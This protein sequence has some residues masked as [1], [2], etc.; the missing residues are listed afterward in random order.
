MYFIILQNCL[1]W[2]DT[3]LLG[4]KAVKEDWVISI[5]ASP[6]RATRFGSWAQPGL[7][8]AGRRLND[9]ETHPGDCDLNSAPTPYERIGEA[10][11]DA[12]LGCMRKAMAATI[13]DVELREG[14]D[15]AFADLAGHMRNQTPA[16]P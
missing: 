3:P 16:A 1:S 7:H 2:R 8:R 9:A 4:G 15:S 12:W 5:D 13:A 6:L 14:L 10:E 11:R